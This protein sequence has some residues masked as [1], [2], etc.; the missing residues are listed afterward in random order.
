MSVVAFMLVGFMLAGYVV[1]DGY[2][3]G[4]ASIAPFLAKNDRERLAAMQAIGPFWNGNEVWLVA[5]GALLFALFPK[6]YASSFS[7]FYLPFMVVLWLLMG[8]GVSL[9]LREHYESPL[10]HQF[11]DAIFTAASAL[12]I[13]LFGV[14]LGNLIR[15]VPLDPDGYFLGT[16]GFL[17]NWYALLVGLFALATL[18]LHGT[19]F[20][21]LRVDGTP[22]ER[23]RA[24]L[25]R[26]WVVTLVIFVAVT[27]ATFLTRSDA[28]FN[29][30]IDVLGVLS[31]A[32]LIAVAF[33]AKRRAELATFIASSAF[34]ALLLGVAAAT[35]YPNLLRGFPDGRG[36]LSI[37]ALSPSPVALA[38]ALGVGIAGM[39][40]VIVY[41]TVLWRKLAGK[42]RVG[43]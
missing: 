32:A 38:S 29:P 15:G 30:W 20:M 14:A 37:Y 22:A 17:L 13:L 5:A 36:S 2:D 41:S 26:L 35:M 19:T 3:L 24:M 27:V 18:A 31:A 6:G 12:L 28:V 33:L 8:R 34:I 16:F 40:I 7:G 1:L 39:V 10:W 42:V 43:E 11:W 23:A 25:P 9:E 21:V 4:V